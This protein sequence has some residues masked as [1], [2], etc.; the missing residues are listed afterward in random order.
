MLGINNEAIPWPTTKP[1]TLL[2]KVKSGFNANTG[3][4]TDAED[5]K[6]RQTAGDLCARNLLT[7]EAMKETIPKLA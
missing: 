2:G 5:A 7:A 1:S 6:L 4:A 3:A